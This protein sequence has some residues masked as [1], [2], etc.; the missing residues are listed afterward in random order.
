MEH[1][2]IMMME[3]DERGTDNDSAPHLDWH[4]NEKLI[5]L[6]LC[7]EEGL[8]QEQVKIAFDAKSLDL[9]ITQNETKSYNLKIEL[10]QPVL[11]KFCIYK[12]VDAKKLVIK[13]KKDLHRTSKNN[14]WWKSLCKDGTLP[15]KESP[16]M[17]TIEEVKKEASKRQTE[18]VMDSREVT[19]IPLAKTSEQTSLVS[20]TTKITHDCYQTDTHVV[21]EVRIKGLKEDCVHVE[22]CD[23]DV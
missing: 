5:I 4:Q 10:A 8:K 15:S 1:D 17:Y 13:M 6:D 18:E 16:P 20:N 23:F 3:T 9:T 11:P 19:E 12:I 21:V 2:K 14:S 7:V 22:F